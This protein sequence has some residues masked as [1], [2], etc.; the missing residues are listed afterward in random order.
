MPESH[1]AASDVDVCEI[2]SVFFQ[3]TVVP[4]STFRSSG[5]KAR[6]PSVSAPIGIVTVEDGTPAGGGVDDGEG[7]GEGEGAGDGEGADDE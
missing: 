2:A 3:T 6:L 7:D 5:A 4:A 1:P